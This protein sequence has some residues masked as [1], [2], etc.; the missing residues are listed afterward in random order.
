MLGQ[1]CPQQEKAMLSDTVI[2]LRSSAEFPAGGKDF[3]S[4]GKHL[5]RH[6][7]VNTTAPHLQCPHRSLPSPT[8]LKQAPTWC[9]EH[10]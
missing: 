7:S 2:S 4:H 5:D 6:L 8:P 9:W 1:P 10:L 3:T